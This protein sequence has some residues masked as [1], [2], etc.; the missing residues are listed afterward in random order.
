M[1]RSV[2]WLQGFAMSIGG[3]GLFVIA[4]LD[5]SFLSLPEINDILVIW[6]VTQ[7][8][9]LMLYY[10]AM[11]TAGSVAGCLALYAVG[12]KGGEALLRRRFSEE[13]LERAFAKF[14]RWGMLALLVP[15]LLPPPAPFKVF[16]LMGGVAGMPLAKFT[17]AI[18]IGRGA[19]YLAE[20]LL[21]VRYG[22]RAIDFV[23]EN[24]ASVALAVSVL[25]AGAGVGYVLWRRR[26]LAPSA[27]GG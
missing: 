10:A 15:A 11:A 23:R 1:E 26:H 2:V 16:V 22:D 12:R 18:T 14:H 20:G 9:S 6:M 4:F 13:Q 24:G 3:P 25:V 5:S 7:Q 17:A 27:D 19:R 21:A 8:K